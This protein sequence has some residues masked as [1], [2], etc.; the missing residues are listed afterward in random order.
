MTATTTPPTREHNGHVWVDFHGLE[1][2]TG[3]SRARLR[4]L[5]DDP[6]FPAGEWLDGQQR[7]A[8][9]RKWYRL[10]Q[11]QE[12]A[13]VLAE[14]AAAELPDYDGDPDEELPAAAAAAVWGIDRTTF[15]KARTR[16]IPL[17]KEDGKGTVPFPINLD[18]PGDLDT[19]PARNWRWTARQLRAF[20]RPGRGKKAS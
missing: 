3:Y 12:L 14:R 2:L 4:D 19:V 7:A 6:A 10:D 9:H 15:T 20:P 13:R 8:G 11:G 16:S 18:E 17:W 1:Q 5:A